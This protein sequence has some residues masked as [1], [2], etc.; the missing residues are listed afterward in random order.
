MSTLSSSRTITVSPLVA[1]QLP[2]IDFRSTDDHT[3]IDTLQHIYRASV[4]GSTHFFTPLGTKAW[5]E[6]NGFASEHVTELDW[7]SERD[8]TLQLSSPVAG[9]EP[10]KQDLRIVATPCQHFSGRSINDRCSTLW[11]SWA[12][13]QEEK[14]GLKGGSVW[15]GGDTGFKSGQS[16]HFQRCDCH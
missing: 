2:V 4:K 15:F 8:L 10:T 7:W 13:V 9:R 1:N 11:A 16:T 12:V 14:K 3:D 6:S 5:F